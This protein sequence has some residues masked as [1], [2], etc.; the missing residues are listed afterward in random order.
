MNTHF[1]QN[2]RD[3]VGRDDALCAELSRAGRSA[4]KR[5][6]F[7]TSRSGECVP[8]LIDAQGGTRPLH[9]LVDPVREGNRI[10]GSAEDDGFLILFGLGGGFSAAAALAQ[11]S[12]QRVLVIEY[13]LES[14]A[15][16][17][18]AKSYAPLLRDER[19][20][21]LV[22]PSAEAVA[23]GVL[24]YY[25]PALSGG[26]RVIPLRVRASADQSRFRSA[27]AAVQNAIA[28]VS[29]DYS[30][31]AHF[32]MRWFS[33]ILRNLLQAG[34]YDAEMPSIRY[35]AI[36]AAGPSLDIHLPILA[37]KQRNYFIIAVD[38]ALP[39]LLHA[40]IEPDA[41]VSIDCQHISYRHFLQGLPAH[42]PLYLDLASPPVVAAQ[43]SC[44]HFFAGGH[45]FA[46]YITQQWRAFPSADTSGGNVTYA[47]LSVAEL[48]G[49]EEIEVYGADFSYPR[50]RSYSRGTYLYPYFESLQNR[51]AGVETLFSE[52]LFRTE[53]RKTTRGDGWYYETET[54]SR[55]RAG[56]EEKAGTLHAAVRPVQGLGAP[57]R[58]A[59]NR[60]AV[61]PAPPRPAR[62]DPPLPAR[63]FLA[64]Y[65]EAV[66]R[67]PPLQSPWAY[68][69]A[70]SPQDRLV[71]TTLLPAGAAVKRRNPGLK[72]PELFEAVKAFSLK[73][74]DAVL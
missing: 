15:E 19:F 11:E 1:Q 59:R 30:V 69:R 29:A 4:E 45:P 52:L 31:Q 44:P 42:I 6:T 26:I 27:A 73:A 53:L 72:T 37:E 60:T 40:G 17:F 32:G 7:L 18:G 20:H 61:P 3:L 23:R 49:A 51:F 9:S 16:L 13:D 12:V 71:F 36:A 25:Q 24:D 65:R 39:A 56:F 54:L 46:Q 43:S 58:I 14:V 41:V 66:R 67:L 62:A 5:Y 63:E 33:N 57:L 74:L 8:A 70:L 50:G 28:A 48:L 55:Y 10:I 21:L 47:A 38:T 68:R 64:A 34:E 2:L 35:A 22:D